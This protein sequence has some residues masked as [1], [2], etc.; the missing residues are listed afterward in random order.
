MLQ[1]G[2]GRMIMNRRRHT[3]EQ[4]MKKLAGGEKLLNAGNDTAEACRKL[5][6]TE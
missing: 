5:E 1:N 3:T 2:L 6:I 4:V